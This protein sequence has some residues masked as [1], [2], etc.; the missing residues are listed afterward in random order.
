M[1]EYREKEATK[2]VAAWERAKF[3]GEQLRKSP[4]FAKLSSS[5]LKILKMQCKKR[6]FR[7]ENAPW[8]AICLS[9]EITSTRS[10]PDADKQHRNDIWE[11]LFQDVYHGGEN[12]LLRIA[13]ILKTNKVR[14]FSTTFV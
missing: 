5:T 4:A 7:D 14:R 10:L 12:N 3:I 13:K 8:A 6:L 1:P 2:F 11:V 9:D